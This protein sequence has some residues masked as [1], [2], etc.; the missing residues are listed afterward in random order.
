MHKLLVFYLV[1]FKSTRYL[2]FIWSILKAQATSPLSGVFLKHKLL[3]LCPEYFKR[4][5][6]LYSIWSILKAQATFPLS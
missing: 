5:S 1:Y 4:T 6:Y 3:V 2:Y